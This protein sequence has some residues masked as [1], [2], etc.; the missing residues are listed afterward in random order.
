LTAVVAI[1]VYGSLYPF[2]FYENWAPGVPFRALL[3]TW[4]TVPGRGDAAANILFY[5]P[6]GFFGVRSF[7]RASSTRVLLVLA[8]GIT[9]SASMELLQFYVVDRYS[10]MADVY[11]NAIGTLAGAVAGLLVSTVFE[12]RM[13]LR[14]AGHGFPLLLLACWLGFR[15]SPYVPVIDLHKYWQAV[16]ALSTFRHLSLPE[17]YRNAGEWIAVAA[18]LQRLPPVRSSGVW[19]S[20]FA[21]GILFARIL[22]DGVSLSPAE[23]AG[24]VVGILAWN[25]GLDRLTKRALVVAVLIGGVFLVLSVFPFHW[26]GRPGTLEWWPFAGLIEE[27]FSAAVPAIFERVFLC[28]SLL[29]FLQNAGMPL[30]YSLAIA[31][32]FAA[33]VWLAGV[34][35]AGNSGD[36]ADLAILAIA[37]GL[38]KALSQSPAHQGTVAA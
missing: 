37:A 38:Q 35:V 31:A 32:L 20:V 13:F 23:L 11:A 19:V 24:L 1:I 18:I 4:R 34:Y 15:L 27:P 10:S 16:Q 3:A 26:S 2:A 25:L 36:P 5:L 6:F 17:L 22:I 14:R 8:G 28:G 30:R 21:A 33:G 7:R 9:L 12:E 29:W